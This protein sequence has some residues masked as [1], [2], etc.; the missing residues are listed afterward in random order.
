MNLIEFCRVVHELTFFAEETQPLSPSQ[1]E[2]VLSVPDS[3]ASDMMD[4]QQ[5]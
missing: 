1:S 3:T 5:D 2:P 4:S